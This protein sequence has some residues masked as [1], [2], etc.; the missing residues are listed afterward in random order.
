MSKKLLPFMLDH[1]VI[2]GVS[3]L[4]RVSIWEE[5]F[6][7]NMKFAETFHEQAVLFKTVC[8]GSADENNAHHQ[9]ASPFVYNAH[10]QKG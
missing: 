8:L 7:L 1:P 9:S 2:H 4:D 6:P 3:C 10:A 5:H